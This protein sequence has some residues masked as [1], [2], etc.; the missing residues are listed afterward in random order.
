MQGRLETSAPAKKNIPATRTTATNRPS[1]LRPNNAAGHIDRDDLRHEHYS[2]SRKSSSL[3]NARHRLTKHSSG[4]DR[5]PT[6]SEDANTNVPALHPRL[7]SK[8]NDEQNSTLALR[9]PKHQPERRRSRGQRMTEARQMAVAAERVLRRFRWSFAA[10]RPAAKTLLLSNQKCCHVA[11]LTAMHPTC[12]PRH[13]RRARSRTGWTTPLPISNERSGWI[14]PMSWRP[15]D[16]GGM[17]WIWGSS[18]AKSVRDPE[19]EVFF[20]RH[21]SQWPIRTS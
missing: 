15:L 20:Q 5:S 11:S 2:E 16:E 13:A 18:H 1:P 19:I 7:R 12:Q 10:P 8:L 6:C 3:G 4:T 14:Q 21:V 17:G 9:Q